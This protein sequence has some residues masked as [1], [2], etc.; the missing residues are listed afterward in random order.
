MV[1]AAQEPADT[2]TA[3]SEIT[4]SARKAP[5]TAVTAID[6]SVNVTDAALA[7]VPELFGGSDM[8]RYLQL[9]SGVTAISDYSAGLAIDGMD[10][11]QNSFRLCG[12]PV[13]FPYHF[14]GIFSTFNSD[15]Y[16]SLVMKRSLHPAGSYD[17]LG[18]II[19]VSPAAA[20]FS[21][22]KGNVNVGMLASQA[23]LAVRPTR[24]LR[25]DVS[26]RI[27][28]IDALYHDMI[29]TENT[30]VRYNFH[31]LDARVQYDMGRCGVLSAVVHHNADKLSY[32]DNNYAM[33]DHLRWRNTLA[34]VTWRGAV[35]SAT[36]Y[37]SDMHSE[38][39]MDME[40]FEL[41]VP[42][43]FR[44]YGASG[45]Y[46]IKAGRFDIYC[47]GAFEGFHYT[48]QWVRSVG[49]EPLTVKEGE[50]CD[51]FLCKAYAEAA[52]SACG[53]ALLLTAGL[54]LNYFI[55]SAGFRT[56]DP[57][58]RFTASWRHST[59]AVSLHIGILRQYV[60]QSGFSDIGMASN[61]KFAATAACQPQRSC[62][63]VLTASQR[64]PLSIYADCEIYY[65]RVAHQPEYMGGVLDLL[66]DDY[67]STDHVI[68]CDGYNVG[69]NIGLRRSYGALT[70][71]ANYAYGVARRR[72]PGDPH[73]FTASSE[74]RHS[75]TATMA[76]DISK[77]WMVNAAFTLASGRPVTPVK[78]LYMIAE[79][80][81]ME[82]GERNAARLP[83]RH[84]LD[85]GAAYTFDTNGGRL[86]HRVALSVINAYGH[87]NVELSTYTY[88]ADTESYGRRMVYS[89]YR[90]LPSLSYSIRF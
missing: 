27:S 45:R 23:H 79:R 75:F 16:P 38:L 31:D 48:P 12:V 34:G 53:E 81:M 22:V 50:A 51:A 7:K 70:A 6:G 11:S 15:Q 26:G 71:M 28:Y 49:V 5:A 30:D 2:V 83:M 55:G 59:G 64:L 33:D 74:I 9:T 86:H 65:K 61:F 25:F 24:R 68:S 18:G 88:N 76:Y 41:S 62:N 19:D 58:P 57:S 29:A 3:L 36:A 69:G 37:Y 56:V 46:D 60:H 14:G 89:L 35:A 40:Q 67:V 44:E 77:H 10:Y 43:D 1:A 63:F 78:A 87:R 54:D 72:T 42:S 52:M 21:G 20:D 66:N 47:G 84:R 17:C 32:G 4:V 39:S 8:L 80:V 85:I 73:Y 13:Q 82:Y 90:F